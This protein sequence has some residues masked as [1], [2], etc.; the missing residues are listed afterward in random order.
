MSKYDVQALDYLRAKFPGTDEQIFHTDYT[1]RVH[2]NI[3]GAMSIC[4]AS[5]IESTCRA[6]QGQCS[7][8]SRSKPVAIIRENPRGY[9]FLVVGWTCE[10]TCRFRHLDETLFAMSGLVKSQRNKTFNNYERISGEITQARNAAMKAAYTGSNLILAGKRG[11][12]KTHL[13]VSIALD[14]MKNGKQAIFRLVNDLL[15]ELRAS[16]REDNF[17][18]TIRRFKEV[19]C[20]ILDD[21]GK[22]RST[23]ACWDYLYQ[24]ADFR[25][26]HEL[27]TIITT[28][29]LTVNELATWGKAE[30]IT[31]ICSR[32]MENGSWVTIE[33]AE[34]YRLKRGAK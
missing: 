8:N 34:D 32:L 25:Y 3:I 18:D 30:Y 12:G 26:R 5:E 9:K 27:Q 1:G 7:L 11:T 6:C 10:L 22:E 15:E 17:A 20:L 14:V 2:E 29:A 24:I 16:V 33:K 13:A 28:N 31:P 19:P 4:Q 23:D 21:L